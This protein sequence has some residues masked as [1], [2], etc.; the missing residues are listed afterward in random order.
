VCGVCVVTC[1]EK[2]GEEQKEEIFCKLN[3]INKNAQSLYIV[4]SWSWNTARPFRYLF[5]ALT[6]V[7]NTSKAGS[8]G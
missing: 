1:R 8:N 7:L 4:L 2:R 6:C 3:S 5:L